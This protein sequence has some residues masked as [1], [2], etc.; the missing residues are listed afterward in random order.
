MRR[1]AIL[2]PLALGTTA[3]I[4]LIISIEKLSAVKEPGERVEN[5]GA[6]RDGLAWGLA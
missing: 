1:L 6:Q 2:S 3:A 4:V 5:E